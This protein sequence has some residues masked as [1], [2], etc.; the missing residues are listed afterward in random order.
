[1]GR[2]ERSRYQNVGSSYAFLY[3]QTVG[4]YYTTTTTCYTT[5]GWFNR[6]TY[7]YQ[8]AVPH[9]YT[10]YYQIALAPGQGASTGSPIVADQANT[11]PLQVTLL[12]VDDDGT[13]NA[14]ADLSVDPGESVDVAV[15]P[16]AGRQDQ[17]QIS[18]LAGDVTVAIGATTQTI[19][20]GAEPVL[21]V[22]VIPTV[23]RKKAPKVKVPGNMKVEP[24]SPA[25]AVIRFSATATDPVDGALPVTCSRL[26]GSVFP[27]GETTVSCTATSLGGKSDTGT[28]TVTVRDIT[29]PDLVSVTPSLTVLPDTDETMPVT[30][31]VVVTDIADTFPVCRITKV[32]GQGK[33]LDQDSVI[34]WQI[35]GDLA[36][37]IEAAARKH[38]DRT[39]SIT[40]KCSDDSQNVSKEK[41]TIVVSHAH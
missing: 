37:N 26:S 14:V 1:M 25:G 3:K 7:C 12:Q 39:Y 21:P 35:T 16:G 19:S 34:D 40:V 33:D 20:Q 6:R 9:T 28:F 13:Q 2:P 24:T 36:L 22:T 38:R 17:I 41:T 5:G 18:A 29:P 31:A 4:T 30:L 27:I 8:V 32:R 23:P 11:E 10:Y 15:Q